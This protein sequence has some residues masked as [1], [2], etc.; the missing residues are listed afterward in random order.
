MTSRAQS[1]K[2]LHHAAGPLLL[3][4]VW[5]AMSARAVAA[6][7]FPAVATTSDGV[8]SSLGHGGR[9]SAPQTEMLAAAARIVRSVSL[10]VSVD[11]EGGYGLSSAE[12]AAWLL[13]TGA[14]GCNIEDSLHAEGALADPDQHAERIAALR[15]S[16][17]GTPLVI[18]ARID[19]FLREKITGGDT[20]QEEL[21]A[22][23]VRRAR[24][25]LS[26]GA[27]CVFPILATGHRTV[28]ELA[29]RIPGPVN[30]LHVPHGP[31][32][33]ELAEAGVA[34]ISW[35]PAVFER[36]RDGLRSHLS[37]PPYA[38]TER[39]HADA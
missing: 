17:G 38:D 4:P 16:A 29:R 11:L 9:E 12:L 33:R 1:L 26:A 21:I 39:E 10:P 25:Y 36:V 15:A 27:D 18:N 8:A 31:S 2:D 3:P 30:I 32:V 34:R 7:G 5:D 24:A 28:R 35:G 14:A 37:G 23:T 22:E 13:D 6:A 19:T 20:P